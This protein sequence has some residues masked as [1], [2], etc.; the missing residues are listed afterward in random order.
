MMADNEDKIITIT[1]FTIVNCAFILDDTELRAMH[2]K[3]MAAGHDNLN[4]HKT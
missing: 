4:T 3:K 1:E 2:M